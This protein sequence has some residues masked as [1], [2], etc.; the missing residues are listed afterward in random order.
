MTDPAGCQS[1]VGTS[2]V[3]ISDH[4]M[5]AQPP[6]FANRP[7]SEAGHALRSYA[8]W[9]SARLACDLGRLIISRFEGRNRRR[10]RVARLAPGVG[11][12]A[13]GQFGL[14]TAGTRSTNV[15]APQSQGC[16]GVMGDVEAW[17]WRK[18]LLRQALHDTGVDRTG[19][20]AELGF[21]RLPAP[22]QIPLG[23]PNTPL[24]EGKHVS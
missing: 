2:A 13:S 18:C 12:G 6:T 17:W 16:P 15:S 21:I 10:P 8:E 3:G 11:P 9:T 5:P 14:R 7:G 4:C 19:Y 23:V 24:R 20:A 22:H 1:P